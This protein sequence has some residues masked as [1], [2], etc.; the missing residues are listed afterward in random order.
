M[1]TD[2]SFIDALAL[3]I[4]RAV[5]TFAAIYMFGWLVSLVSSEEPED[6]E[7]A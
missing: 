6:D 3:Q 1:N 7:I 4:G 2:K 5:L